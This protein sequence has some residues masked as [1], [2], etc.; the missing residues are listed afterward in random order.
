MNSRQK[1]ARETRQKLLKTGKLL[2]CQKG[3]DNISV[4]EI[5][6]A[7]GVSKGTFYTYFK[8]KED[9]LFQVSRE[10]FREILESAMQADGD[11]LA[12][13]TAYMV[14]FS[15]CIEHDSVHLAQDWVSHVVLPV[16]PESVYDR[17]KLPFDLD[18]VKTL[19]CSGIEGGM[20]KPDTPA[21]LI[22]HTLVDILYGQMLCWAM[23]D[24]VYSL[25]ERTREFCRLYLGTLFKDYLVCAE[26]ADMVKED[27][28]NERTGRNN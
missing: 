19:L 7:A 9:I 18:S 2:I 17:E 10:T 6:R 4:E 8:R 28:R 22:A 16:P 23:S 26:D 25:K 3:L 13:L 11:F 1:A 20:L 15:Q 5:T 21:E 12:K 27:E 14:S 24:G